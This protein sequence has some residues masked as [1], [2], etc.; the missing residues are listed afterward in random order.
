LNPGESSSGSIA[1]PE[2]ALMIVGAGV[3]GAQVLDQLALLHPQHRYVIVGRNLERVQTRVNL[4][5]YVCANWGLAPSIAAASADIRDAGQFAELILRTKPDIVF[6]ATT[7][8]PWWKIDNLPPAE[9]A[10]A[11]STGPGMWAPLDAVL[12]LCLSEAIAAAGVRSCFVN[13]CYPD[14]INPF[15]SAQAA[16]ASIGVGNISN[17]IPGLKL[18]FGD[19][20]G[21]PHADLRITLVCHH[22]TSLNA[23]VPEGAPAAP[24]YLR[25]D[26]GPRSMEYRDE[27]EPFAFFRARFPRPRGIAGQAV[28]A[29]SAASLLAALLNSVPTRLHAPGPLGLPGGYPVAIG[30]D[31]SFEIDIG[32]TISLSEARGINERGQRLDGVELAAAGLLRATAEAAAA[33]RSIVGFDLPDVTTDVVRDLADEAV[34]QLNRRFGLGIG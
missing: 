10:L 32:Q 29:S 28:T 19:Q 33:F 6:N 9:A 11:N 12:P 1:A 15:L 4:A 3:L 24:Y 18:A 13:G 16:P 8:F 25:V 34:I 27:G 21:V 22:F 7:P 20:F 2:K 17:I 31:G 30:A 14:A 5:K 23:P 26:G